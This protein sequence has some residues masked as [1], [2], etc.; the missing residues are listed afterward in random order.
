MSDKFSNLRPYSLGIVVETKPRGIDYILVSPL[1]TLNIQTPGLIKEYN[2]EYKG[3]HADLESKSF[4][5][6][7]ESK[8]YLKAKWLP[9]GES[10]RTSAPDVVA[11]ETVM[12]YKFGDVDEYYWFDV[13]REPELRRLEDVL[14]SYS[15]KPNGIDAFDKKSS[16]WVRYN[17]K[18]KYIY[19]HTSDNDGEHT[20]Y[21]LIIDTK[22]GNITVK[23]GKGNHLVFDSAADTLSAHFNKQV[24]ITAGQII[25]L[26]A[27]AI[28]H[29]TPIV[30]NTG[31]MSTEGSH[32]AN[33][34]CNAVKSGC[35]VK[36]GIPKYKIPEL[37]R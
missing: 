14:Y 3:D 4:K 29:D 35:P 2:K 11:N 1:E 18:D 17:T 16:Y 5:T 7:H 8:N 19:L 22:E 31:K 28:V 12:I 27:P 25:V 30:Y 6:E 21:D 34:N 24:L 13:M 23:D 20:V 36:V 33:P 26:K 10:N 9:F 15:N 32:H 37:K